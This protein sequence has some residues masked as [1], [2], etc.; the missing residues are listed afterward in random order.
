M[1][2]FHGLE[3]KNVPVLAEQQELITLALCGHWMQS[4][5][6]TRAMNDMDGWMVRERERER[7]GGG[8]SGKYVMST[9]LHYIYIVRYR[10]ICLPPTRQDLTQGQ[11]PKGRL[12]VRIKGGEGRARIEARTLLVIDPLSAMW[13]WWTLLDMDP[14]LGPGTYA[15]L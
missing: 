14:N 1:T 5:R 13:G 11:W 15:W 12:K 7:E 9:R 2:F 4:R 6:L 8:D 10:N 3:H